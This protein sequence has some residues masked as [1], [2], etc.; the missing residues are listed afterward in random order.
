MNSLWRTYFLL[1]IGSIVFT[2]ATVIV[3]WLSIQE[4]AKKELSYV[5]TIIAHP[6]VALLDKNEALLEMLGKRLV[7]INY[8]QN[9]E[10]AQRLL[11]EQTEQNNDLV[12]IGLALPSGQLIL[13]SSNISPDKLPNFLEKEET[14]ASFTQ[15]L[16]ADVMVV[17]R[18][19][20][21]DAIQQWVI[22]IRKRILDNNNNVIAVMTSG[23]RLA[24]NT[25]P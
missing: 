18:T 17:G 23:L 9:K 19:Y 16:N 13:T 12:G 22:P 6:M 14:S 11:T 8:S 24:S 3:D 21:L 2:C 10:H 15:T 4:D 20:Y 1:V 7:E 5:N 25:S